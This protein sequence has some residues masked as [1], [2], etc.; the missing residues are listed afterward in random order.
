MSEVVYLT[1]KEV[2]ARIRVSEQTLARWELERRGPRVLRPGGRPRYIEAEVE[3]WM[4]HP[5]GG[6]N[7]G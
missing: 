1:R 2:A 4:A 6:Q 7:D 3:S 5:D